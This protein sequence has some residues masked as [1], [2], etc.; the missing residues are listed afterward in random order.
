MRSWTWLA[1]KGAKLETDG[2]KCGELCVLAGDRPGNHLL[3]PLGHQLY[4]MTHH[5]IDPT[6]LLF[7]ATFRL[8][9]WLS[10]K[11]SACSAN[12]GSILG[13]GKSLEKGM[14]THFSIL[15]WKIP[16][17]AEGGLW[18][19]GLQRVGHDWACIHKPTFIICTLSIKLLSTMSETHCWVLFKQL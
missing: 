19:T 4:V 3:S 18:S 14:A 12:E 1:G 15:A 5:W 8:H 16:W 2:G 9:W 10:G 6:L 7:E 11:E 13:S 17:T